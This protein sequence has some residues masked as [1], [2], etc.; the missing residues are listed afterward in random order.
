MLHVSLE[1]FSSD[2]TITP[3]QI[4][5]DSSGPE[6]IIDFMEDSGGGVVDAGTE[7]IMGQAL[8]FA[9]LDPTQQ[10]APDPTISAASVSYTTPRDATHLLVSWSV[11]DFCRKFLTRHGRKD[12][13]RSQTRWQPTGTS[14]LVRPSNSQ[15]S[16]HRHLARSPWLPPGIGL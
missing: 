14:G 9:L 13:D 2:V 3:T 12:S 4:L 1:A 5:W 15:F 8:L 7:Y 11:V 6:F 16:R 10:T